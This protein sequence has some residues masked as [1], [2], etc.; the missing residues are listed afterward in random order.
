VGQAVIGYTVFM[1]ELFIL[2]AAAASVETA[3]WTFGIV[4]A[5]CALGIWACVWWERG[6][7]RIVRMEKG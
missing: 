2:L 7:R 3:L 6:T 1:I 5:G 4:H